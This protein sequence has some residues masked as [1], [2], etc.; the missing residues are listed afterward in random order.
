MHTITGDV[1]VP[2]GITLTIQ[3]GAIVKF[4]AMTGIVVQ[5]GGSLVT[6]GTVAQPI[7]LTSWRDDTAGGDT[8]G[9]GSTTVPAAGDWREIQVN[10]HAVFQH[11]D[12]RYGG[13]SPS[14]TWNSSGTIVTGDSAVLS[15][16]NSSLRDSLFD[17]ILVYAAPASIASIVSSQI[18]GTNRA[19]VTYPGAVAQV[20]NDTLDDNG[21]GLLVHQGSMNVANTIVAESLQTGIQNY[22]GTLT[23][24]RYSDVW[25]PASANYHNYVGTPDLTGQFGNISADPLFTN[26]AQANYRLNYGSPAI[27]AADGTVAPL[28][29]IL[30]DPRYKDPGAPTTGIPMPGSSAVPDMGAYEFVA[31]ATSNV[32]LIVSATQGPLVATA[33]TQV[34]VNWTD[35]NRGSGLAVGPWHDRISFL[36]DQ[37][38]SGANEIDIA[39]VPVA[40]NLGPG[41]SASY[42]ATV[43]VPGATPGS[44][45][46]RI[47]TNVFGEVFEGANWA[48]NAGPLSAPMQ[49]Q[50]QPLASTATLA[51]AFDNL[52]SPNWYQ[53]GQA[54]G[55][56]IVVTLNMASGSARSHL[57]AAAGYM[58]TTQTFGQISLDWNVPT[59]RLVLA[60]PAQAQTVYLLAQPDSWTG[61]GQP[62][63]LITQVAQFSLQS[64]VVTQGGNAGTTTVP[65]LGSGF[66]PGMSAWLT[67]AGGS[68]VLSATMMMVQD[69]GDALATFNLAGAA[70]GIYNFNVALGANHASLPGAFTVQPSTGGV[71]DA[72]LLV[73][74]AVR[75]LRPFQ[76]AVLFSNV[77]N[78]DLPVPLLVVQGGAGNPVWAADAGPGAA[79]SQL[80]ILALPDGG[81]VTSV[82][83]PG[84]S[85]ELYFN[86]Q[87]NAPGAAQYALLSKAGNSID[88]MDWAALRTALSP[89]SPSPQYAQ[90]WNAMTPT[91]GTTY[92]AYIGALV[93][94][95]GEAQDYG[96]DLRSVPDLLDYMIQRQVVRLPGASLEGTV[97]SPD[98]AHPLGNAQLVL[99]SQS[100]PT[101]TFGAQ[102][103][104]DGRFA[105]FGISAGSYKLS[106]A[107]QMPNPWGALNVPAAGIPGQLTVVTQGGH[108]LSG[109][110]TSA[111]G[112][113]PVQG[114][115]VEL[116]D[117]SGDG[118]G[119]LTDA[120][121]DYDITGQ[122]GGQYSLLVS[123][124]DYESLAVPSTVITG[125]APAGL[126]LTLWPGGSVSGRVVDA[127]G[128][129]VAGAQVFARMISDD[130]GQPPTF[131]EAG[132]RVPKAQAPQR[133][134]MS[135]AGLPTIPTPG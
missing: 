61:T 118:Y 69:S 20:I 43:R 113:S 131:P 12:L 54:A 16:V 47:F 21:T 19:I 27:D 94:A 30:G 11:A 34:T 68:K 72:R 129:G 29:D 73:P 66:A 4:G 76:G 110:I 97:Y 101:S 52:A 63:T 13:G 56:Q 59:A 31:T 102:T 119:A 82:L 114:A 67:P 89:S 55:Q 128:N 86:T 9:D 85:A 57:Y 65:V 1:I 53:I 38:G 116:T 48:N 87:I 7:V 78:D 90:A 8:N 80:E 83:R 130:Q 62:Y 96:L 46:W 60:A 115:Q 81:P 23:G 44:W 5:P 104:Y 134:P 105:F 121:G 33:G 84:Q 88:P 50:V 92:G 36:A 95:A 125:S 17:G 42:Q 10:G 25:A 124:Q 18:A 26:P 37:P 103:F 28:T 41:Q 126:S 107:G 106:V 45:R 6:L 91:I 39:D 70:T 112:G 71:L 79:A 133:R 132:A 32:N 111:L 58:P 123:A 75:V 100:V 122:A 74:A 64:L 127:H 120:N 99:A 24:V 14:G 135:R 109:Q 40:G 108:A 22:E 117:Q 2:S 3:A 77:G 51:S 93:L 15:F 35:L 49:L 98:L